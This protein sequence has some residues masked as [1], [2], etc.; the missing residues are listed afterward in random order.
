M[1][2][3]T[4]RKVQVDIDEEVWFLN[5]WNKKVNNLKVTI[6]FK[7]FVWNLMYILLIVINRYWPNSHAA[8][9]TSREVGTI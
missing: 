6:Y 4:S 2:L 9:I 7:I 3:E 8:R 1:V 5:S